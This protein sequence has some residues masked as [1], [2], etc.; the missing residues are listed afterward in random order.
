MKNVIADNFDEHLAAIKDLS[1]DHIN[2]IVDITQS[3]IDC[4]KNGGKLLL[5]G[6]GGSAQDAEHIAAEL[7]GHTKKDMTFGLYSGGLTVEPLRDA[8]DKM[9]FGK[10]VMKLLRA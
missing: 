8:V 3:I 6:N 10:A 1:E 5:F 7:V 2:V 4:Y 9:N